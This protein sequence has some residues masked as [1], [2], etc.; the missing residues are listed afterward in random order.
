MSL[1]VIES[2]LRIDRDPL[3][4]TPYTPFSRLELVVRVTTSAKRELSAK[5]ERLVN[6]VL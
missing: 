2:G 6:I 1:E 5:H 4:H 3:K